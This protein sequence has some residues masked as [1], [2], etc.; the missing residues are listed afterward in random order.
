MARFLNEIKKGR[1]APAFFWVNRYY[2]GHCSAFFAL[3]FLLSL[4]S[5]PSWLVWQ[6]ELQQLQKEVAA[7]AGAAAQ[8]LHQQQQRRK[9]PEQIQRP[10]RVDKSFI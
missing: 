3:A 5:L 10:I 8:E 7:G 1:V 4:L 6:Q 9:L 2:F